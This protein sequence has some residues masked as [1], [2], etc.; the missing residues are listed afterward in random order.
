MRHAYPEWFTPRVECH[1]RGQRPK[2][3]PLRVFSTF[4]AALRERLGTLTGDLGTWRCGYCGK[5]HTVTATHLFGPSTY[6]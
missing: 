3:M 1:C 2:Q 4:A 6:P 5:V